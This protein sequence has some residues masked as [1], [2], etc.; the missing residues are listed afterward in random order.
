MRKTFFLLLV[1]L[2]LINFSSL[3]AQSKTEYCIL[4]IVNTVKT[5]GVES[6]LFIDLGSSQTHSL[7]NVFENNKNGTISVKNSDGSTTII[8]DEV[9]FLPIIEQYGFKLIEVY[10]NSILEKSY[11]NYLFEK[12]N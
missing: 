2:G 7:K 8:K 12:K 10:S 11:V 5:T 1:L 9:D 6:K 3:H 4:R